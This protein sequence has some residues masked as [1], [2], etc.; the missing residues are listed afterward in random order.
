MIIVIDHS[1]I[2]NKLSCNNDIKNKF[3]SKVTE[4]CPLFMSQKITLR[5]KMFLVIIELMALAN[6][7]WRSH[8]VW[9]FMQKWIYRI[10]TFLKLYL[11]LIFLFFLIIWAL[12]ITIILNSCVIWYHSKK[13]TCILQLIFNL[14]LLAKYNY[15]F[16]KFRKKYLQLICRYIIYKIVFKII[17]EYKML[18]FNS[19][20]FKKFSL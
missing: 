6:N 18:Y 2:F 20:T 13:T 1:N 12:K 16:R 19:G 9:H 4:K 15:I 3:M 8:D 7:Y 5:N 10:V 17:N 14:F 11:K